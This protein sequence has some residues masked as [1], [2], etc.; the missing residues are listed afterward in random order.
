MSTQRLTRRVPLSWRAA[1]LAPSPGAGPANGDPAAGRTDAVPASAG[2]GSADPG[3]AG[4]QPVGTRP[5]DAAAASRR[6]LQWPHLSWVD[7]A[8]VGFVGLNLA[9]MRLLPTWQTVPF[10]AIWVSLTVI[11]GFRLWRL[12]PTILTLAA[13]TLRLYLPL[14]GALHLDFNQAYRAISWLAWVPNLALAELLLAGGF[15]TSPLR[16]APSRSLG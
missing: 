6:V 15:R 2:R 14:A 1:P 4:A 5:G 10:L 13:V 11:Y 7:I 8:W 9:A 12:Q 3:S 16:A